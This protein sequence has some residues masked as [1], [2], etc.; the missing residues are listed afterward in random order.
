MGEEPQPLTTEAEL[1]HSNR[2]ILY[3]MFAVVVVMTIAAAP[4][5]GLRSA[6]GVIVGGLLAW[7]NFRWLDSSTRAILVDPLV[8]TTPI[9][10][11][12][13]VIRY[14][15][16][17]AVLL[18]IYYYDLLPVVAVIAGLGSFAL[19]VVLRGLKSIFTGSL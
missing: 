2:G 19:A 11:M 9:L 6:L 10:A 8:A 5:Y 3:L 15:L 13:Y 17:A 7:L 18:V 16:I 12:R 4:F 14:V 1:R